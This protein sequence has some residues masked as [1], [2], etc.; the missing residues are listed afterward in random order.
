MIKWFKRH[1]ERKFIKD[2]FY[3][4]RVFWPHFSLAQADEILLHLRTLLVEYENVY[5]NDNFIEFYKN[6]LDYKYLL[7]RSK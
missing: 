2:A 7:R 6:R 4:S 3:Y 1:R 5:G